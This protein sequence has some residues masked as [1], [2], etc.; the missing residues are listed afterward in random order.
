MTLIVALPSP[1]ASLATA[2]GKGFQLQRLM[3]C[4]LPVPPAFVI[5][6]DAYRAHIEQASVRTHLDRIRAAPQTEQSVCLAQLRAAITA[7]P[8]D[9]TLRAGVATAVEQLGDGPLAVRSSATTEDGAWHSFAGQH[10]TVLGVRGAEACCDAIRHC[11]ASLW[12]ERAAA[13]RAQHG[14]SAGAA[15]MAV[16]LQQCVSADV[17]GVLFTLDPLRGNPRHLVIE[18]VF[19]L[20]ESL[21]SGRVA[22]HRWVI[23]RTSR[24]V[25]E[26]AAALQPFEL[27]ADTSGGTRERPLAPAGLP[28]PCL[29]NAQIQQLADFGLAA[30]HAFG[31]PQDVEWGIAGQHIFLVQARPVTTTRPPD[32]VADRRVW[33][34][35]NTSEVAPDVLRPMSFAVLRYFLDGLVRRTLIPLGFGAGVHLV[36]LIAG[37]AYFNMNPIAALMR[38]LPFLTLDPAKG[39]GG[40]AQL[41]AAVDQLQDRDLPPMHLSTWQLVRL[42]LSS[43]FWLLRPRTRGDAVMARL[44]ATTAALERADIAQL[45]DPAVLARI[46]ALFGDV[47]TLVDGLLRS[48]VGLGCAAGLRVVCRRWLGDDDGAMANRLLSGMGGL[49]SA[50]AGLDLWRLAEAVRT[51]PAT[52]ASGA[53]FEQ[54]RERL[55]TSEPGRAFLAQWD[56]FMAR[57]GHHTR[58]EVD[59]A[60]PR[61]CEDPDYVLGMIRGYGGDTGHSPIAM[62]EQCGAERCALTATCRARLRQPRRWVFDSLLARA[63]RGMA[64]RENVK[65]EVVRRIALARAALLELAARFVARGFCTDRDDIFFLTIE[66]VRDIVRGGSRLDVAATVRDRRAEYVTNLALTPAAVIVGQFDP[67]RHVTLPTAGTVTSVL[68]GLAVSPGVVRGRARVIL[69]AD[70]EQ[71]LL[72][73][74]ILVAPFTDPGW[75]PYFLPAAAI[76]VDVGG[77]LSHGSIVAR[78]YGI[79]AVV[80]VGPATQVIRTGD[81]IEV[82]AHCGEVRLL[83]DAADEAIPHHATPGS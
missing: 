26:H 41:V 40:D 49:D 34:N 39:F 23:D 74:E 67:R 47:D 32:D 1:Q 64:L 45:P 55:A 43:T 14:L 68:R 10:D 37:R 5:L 60:L 78:E 31:G 30:E 83:R 54:V 20:G 38:R 25:I 62:H 3:Q 13:Y 17:A 51:L 36:G 53:P 24:D 42:L 79:P 46:D 56:V 66:E 7:A 63:Q 2:G 73:G 18:A 48:V 28:P 8:L 57:H 59:V 11:W 80:N 22:P 52:V 71:R 76:V 69:R 12:S 75:T 81:L 44:R 33:A 9:T 21:V 58:V 82:D 50:D 65:S 61:W 19:G 4:G 15:A 29:T 27:V 77:A 16:V 72:P 6:A 70:A 35:T